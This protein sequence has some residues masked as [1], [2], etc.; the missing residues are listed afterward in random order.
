MVQPRNLL[1]LDYSYCV[2]LAH[3]TTTRKFLRSCQYSQRMVYIVAVAFRDLV[4]QYQAVQY[5]IDHDNPAT[6]VSLKTVTDAWLRV[7]PGDN[8]C[9][10]IVNRK[11]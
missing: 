5:C 2:A 11:F 1:E 8:G 3:S 6:V 10:R 9:T 7:L 4:Q